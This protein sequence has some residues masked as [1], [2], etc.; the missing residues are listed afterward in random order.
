MTYNTLEQS[1]HDGKP[2]EFYKFTLDPTTFAFLTSS[3]EEQTYLSDTYTPE[4]VSRGRVKEGNESDAG[5]VTVTLPRTHPIAARFIGY[6]PE[7][8]IRLVIYTRHRG[9]LE[10]IKVFEGS[11]STSKFSGPSV[12]LTCL[13]DIAA[14]DQTV[15][16]NACGAQ[17]Q[18]ALYSQQCGKSKVD[19]M[20]SGTVAVVSADTVQSSAFAG[21]PSGWLNNG[22]LER[23]TGERRFV[24]N[25]VGA[26]VTLMSPFLGLAVGESIT[27]YAGCDR[28]E[29]VCDSKFN[30]HLRFLGFP[31]VPT[32]NPFEVGVT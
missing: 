6:A 12:E 9:D 3:D 16:R 29:A 22:W 13:P 24:V 7:P 18:W 1:A 25:H 20:L 8:S 2:V 19:F 21:Q 26:T 15:P 28:T 23:A 32:K 10:V 30:N 17:C 11:V 14:E 4:P 5:A 31:R 27:G